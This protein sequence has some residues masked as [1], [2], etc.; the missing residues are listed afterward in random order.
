[1]RDSGELGP[2]AEASVDG[3]AVTEKRVGPRFFIHSLIHLASL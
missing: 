3:V 2:M 1:M